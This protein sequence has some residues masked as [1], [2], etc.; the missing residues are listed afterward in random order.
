MR[1]HAHIHVPASSTDRLHNV[2]TPV[3]DAGIQKGGFRLILDCIAAK[4][5]LLGGSGGMPPRKIPI[6]RQVLVG[7][8]HFFLHQLF[9]SSPLAF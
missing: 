2:V 9:L 4:R 5:P 6:R 1:A 3:A 7:V 8:R